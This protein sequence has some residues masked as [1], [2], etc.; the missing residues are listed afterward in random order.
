[1]KCRVLAFD[2]DSDHDDYC[3]DGKPLSFAECV[4]NLMEWNV[5]TATVQDKEQICSALVYFGGGYA[6]VCNDL[7]FS[8]WKTYSI[9]PD[10][11][12]SAEEF[13][14]RCS[15][16]FYTPDIGN[17]KRDAHKCAVTRNKFRSASAISFSYPR[18]QV[19]TCRSQPS[20]NCASKKTTTGNCNAAELLPKENILLRSREIK[21]YTSSDYF[22]PF[23]IFQEGY[24][25]DAQSSYSTSPLSNKTSFQSTSYQQLTALPAQSAIGKVVDKHIE[26]TEN[27]YLAW[28]RDY[29]PRLF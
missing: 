22:H 9:S 17:K 20:L 27:K 8:I 7:G 12:S 5:D 24:P 28:E 29:Y 25:T 21:N 26:L 11:S 4:E 13:I 15:R 1:M 18:K 6:G 16:Q 23:S 10:R 14:W 3:L 19:F 2:S